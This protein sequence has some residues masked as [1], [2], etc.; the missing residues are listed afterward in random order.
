MNAAISDKV[1][2]FVG[3]LDEYLGDGQPPDEAL[4]A[5]VADYAFVYHSND[6]RTHFARAAEVTL[7][8]LLEKSD[9]ETVA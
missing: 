4:R 5:T 8:R 2:F 3:M 7:R 1:T 6:G 9:T